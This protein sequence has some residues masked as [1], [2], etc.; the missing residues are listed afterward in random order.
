M[1]PAGESF[2]DQLPSLRPLLQSK[3]TT[4]TTAM[5]GISVGSGAKVFQ[6]LFVRFFAKL[7][8]CA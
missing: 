3:L 6:K 5:M 2:G 8:D 7:R 1:G 4:A